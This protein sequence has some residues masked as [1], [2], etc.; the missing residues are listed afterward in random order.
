M[1]L[2]RIDQQLQTDQLAFEIS[3]YEMLAIKAL[4]STPGSQMPLLEAWLI[5]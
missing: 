1:Y 3:D 2:I 4:F 5:R